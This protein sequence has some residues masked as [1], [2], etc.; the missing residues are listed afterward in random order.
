MFKELPECSFDFGGGIVGIG[1]L[2]ADG[3]VEPNGRLGSVAGITGF[4]NKS[5]QSSC[6]LFNSVCSGC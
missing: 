2:R 5:A 3:T 1:N 4:V 6:G